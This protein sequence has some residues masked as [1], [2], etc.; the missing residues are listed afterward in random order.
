MQAEPIR[1]KSLRWKSRTSAVRAGYMILLLQS[2]GLFEKF[3][4]EYWPKYE[5]EGGQK[6][7]RNYYKLVLMTSVLEPKH[8]YH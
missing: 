6:E 5:T 4:K 3:Q 2:K 7:D 8:Y 1:K